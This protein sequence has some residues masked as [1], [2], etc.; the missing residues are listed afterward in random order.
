[1]T[2]VAISEICLTHKRNRLGVGASGRKKN[3]DF[4]IRCCSHLGWGKLL[5][6]SMIWLADWCFI[7]KSSVATRSTASPLRLQDLHCQTSDV[8]S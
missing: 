4:A 5:Q 8:C 2:L 7:R 6:F 1:M 3:P